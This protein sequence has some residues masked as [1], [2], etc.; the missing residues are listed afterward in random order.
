MSLRLQHI[1]WTCGLRCC[2]VCSNI[3]QVLSTCQRGK[4]LRLYERENLK[5]LVSLCMTYFNYD[6][7]QDDEDND[8]DDDD[9]DDDQD[10]DHD[11]DDD[12]NDNDQDTSV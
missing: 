5:A 2:S 1:T 12:D 4:T 11:Q 8:Q 3:F 10:D 6:N 7:D 9:Q